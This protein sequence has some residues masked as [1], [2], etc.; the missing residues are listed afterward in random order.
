[1]FGNY[2]NAAQAYAQVGM[3]TGAMA[4]SPHKLISI[5]LDGAMVAITKARQHMAAGNVLEK[6]VAIN[7]AASIIDSGLRGSLNM[8][9]G[10]DIAEN[11]SALYN[12]M[13]LSLSTAHVHNDQAK[14]LEVYKLLAGLKNTW[15]EIDPQTVQAAAQME[16]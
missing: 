10:G 2:Q 12:Y 14:L 8:T 7:H 5:L 11:L 16:A 6:G 13:T 1:M 4:A 15:D 3:Q 9:D